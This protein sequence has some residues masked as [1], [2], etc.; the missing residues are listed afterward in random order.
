MAGKIFNFLTD[1]RSELKKVVWPTKR[2]M[3]NLT[4]V[5]VA[6][7]FIVGLFLTGADFIFGRLIRTIIGY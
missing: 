1:A 2:E 4:I 7:S 6:V 5:V 3:M